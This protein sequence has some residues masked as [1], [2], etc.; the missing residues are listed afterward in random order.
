M[1]K[2]FIIILFVSAASFSST[3]QLKNTKWKGTIMGDNP[4]NVIFDFRKDSAFVFTV[5]D[6]QLVE[7]MTYTAGSDW[8][9]VNKIEGQSDC[10]NATPGKYSFSINGDRMIMKVISD[11]CGD[12]YTALDTTRWIRWKDHKAV[13]LHESILSQ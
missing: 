6:D 5:S 12:R 13:T 2:L 10:D 9:T 7:A 11:P 8:F 4:R 1:K 3:A